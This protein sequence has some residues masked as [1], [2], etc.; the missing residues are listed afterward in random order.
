[1]G[2]LFKLSHGSCFCCCNNTMSCFSSPAAHCPRGSN[3]NLAKLFYQNL[4]AGI[5]KKISF[6]YIF[7]VLF[8]SDS[9]LNVF[10]TLTRSFLPKFSPN[11]VDL[12]FPS[13]SRFLCWRRR[14]RRTRRRSGDTQEKTKGP[15]FLSVTL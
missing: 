3:G 13:P 11:S 1:M 6:N 4:E 15:T 2:F 10:S 14:R 7:W 8:D 9:L 5:E 12:G